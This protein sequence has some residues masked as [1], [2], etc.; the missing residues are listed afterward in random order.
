MSLHEAAST[1]RG[2]GPAQLISPSGERTSHPDLDPW[3]E[4]IDAPAL[5]A[6][7]TDMVA[8]RRIDTEATALQRQ[9]ELALW[10]PLLGQEA[11][12]IGSGRAL[13]ESDFVFSS[14][15][16]NGVAFC[17]GVDAEDILRVW[18]GNAASGWDPFELNMATPQIIIGAQTLHAAGYAMGI[19]FDGGEEAAIT[20]FGDGATSQGDVNEALVFAA[21]YQA[22]V[23]FFC[24]NNHWAIS[25]PVSLQTHTRIVDRAAGFG[26]PGIR[27]DGNDVLACLAAT[28]QALDR[29]R[30]G[31]GPTFIEAVTYRMGPHTTADDPT[32][33]R[34]ANE[35][36]DWRAKDPIDRLEAHLT[37]LG[38]DPEEFNG[39][40]SRRADEV[41]AKLRAG[42]IAMLDPEPMDVFE[43]VYATPNTWLERQKQHYSLYLEQ[44]AG[45]PAAE[46]DAR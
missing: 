20:Y 30:S 19:K 31:N 38:L 27:V 41:A 35:L 23:V 11:A 2:G 36:E 21:S 8:V 29:A 28:R 46:G 13:R 44:F 34:D 40:A 9:G 24:Q 39:A 26:I 42:V 15:R 3:V 33:Y 5:A 22:P 18:R 43:H 16:E 37:A 17:R 7:Y 12:Q 32:R 1:V 25:E 45:A 4:D 14:Y 6:L 10:P